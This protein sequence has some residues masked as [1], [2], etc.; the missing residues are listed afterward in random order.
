MCSQQEWESLRRRFEEAL[1]DGQLRE[2]AA[3][4]IAGIEAFVEEL[5]ARRRAGTG[6]ADAAGARGPSGSPEAKQGYFQ[7]QRQNPPRPSVPPSATFF[8]RQAPR[9]FAPRKG[10]PS[11]V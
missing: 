6:S 11:L 1:D 7:S 2:L 4:A 5:R 3:D 9:R 8:A 10:E